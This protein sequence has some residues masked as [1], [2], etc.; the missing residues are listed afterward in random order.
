MCEGALIDH[1][2]SM[3]SI[4]KKAFDADA[5]AEALALKSSHSARLRYHALAPR[6][7][8]GK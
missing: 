3:A 2:D 8:D 1:V 7:N 4:G 5:F 6:R